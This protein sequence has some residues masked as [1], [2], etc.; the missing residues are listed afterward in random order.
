[1]WCGVTV[2]CLLFRQ[3]RCLWL[4]L[5]SPPGH[6]EEP[7]LTEAGRDA[8]DRLCRLCCGEL[9]V[10]GGGVP[11]ATQPVLVK[12][13]ELVKDALN[14]LIGVVSATFPLCQVRARHRVPHQCW[15]GGCPALV[16]HGQEGASAVSGWL[17]G[18]PASRLCSDH[19]DTLRISV[20]RTIH[21]LTSFYKPSKSQMFVAV[22]ETTERDPPLP[23]PSL[24]ALSEDGAD[25]PS[26]RAAPEGGCCWLPGLGGSLRARGCGLP[27]P[28]C[29]RN[30]YRCNTLHGVSIS[31]Y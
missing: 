8:F 19:S 27:S 29:H 18:W 24:S 3:L 10:L 22:G 14:V 15:V 28:R 7:Y 26:G 30:V 31:A 1:M 12:E 17:L 6:R 16:P 11:P 4:C 21:L 2:S 13:C 5:H 20:L 25:W 23:C 9:Q